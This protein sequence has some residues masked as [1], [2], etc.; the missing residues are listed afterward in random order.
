MQLEKRWLIPGARWEQQKRLLDRFNISPLV[1]Q[2]L[3]NRGLTEFEDV[4]EFLY[5]DTGKMVDWNKIP[6]IDRAVSRIIEA[7]RK[8]EKVLVYGDYDVDGITA[9]A[10]LVSVLERMGMDDVDYYIPDRMEEG[11]GL[12]E[13]AITWAGE[14]GVDLVITVD[15]GIN[16]NAEVEL[17][18]RLGMD[19][20]ITDHHEPPRDLPQATAVVNPKLGEEKRVRDLAGVGVAFKL[21]QA[22]EARYREENNRGLG[23]WESIDLVTLGTVA[24]MVPLL[25][26]NRILV[27]K[28]LEYLPCS[29]R[30]GIQELVRVSG[31]AGKEINCG[32]VGF[33]LAPRINAVGRLG[34]ASLA[35]EL[36]LT[37]SIQRAAELAKM[38]DSENRERQTVEKQIFQDV[39]AQIERQVDLD[40][41]RVIVLSSPLWHS[42]VIGIVASKIV[43]R[44]YR[45][46]I[47]IAQ[48]GDYGKASARSIS[49]FDIY[50]ALEHC[51]DLL[52]R[53]GGHKQAA[54][55]TIKIDKIE[56][57]RRAINELADRWLTEEQMQPTIKLDC[58]MFLHQVDTTLVEQLELLEPFGFGNPGPVFC[59]RE[60]NLIDCRQVGRDKKHA[61]MV[62]ASGNTSLPAIGFNIQADQFARGNHKI[63]LAFVPEKNYWQGKVSLQLN[64]KDIRVAKPV[65]VERCDLELN[66]GLVE[67]RER[68]LE[69]LE[70][71]ERG[72]LAVDH[73][74]HQDWLTLEMAAVLAEGHPVVIVTPLTSISR[75]LAGVARLCLPEIKVQVFDG[76]WKS[77]EQFFRDFTAQ[78]VCIM[79][80]P[81]FR[82]FHC[83]LP[84]RACLILVNID[85]DKEMLVNVVDQYKWYLIG[86]RRAAPDTVYQS[87]VRHS[88]EE[89]V[90]APGAG[91]GVKKL[92]SVFHGGKPGV[93]FTSLPSEVE[94]LA[95]HLQQYIPGTVMPY[96]ER[97]SVDQKLNIINSFQKGL[98]QVIVS[99]HG[100]PLI[101]DFPLEI[102][103]LDAPFN[104]WDYQR[105]L[106]L[107]GRVYRLF[108]GSSWDK[109]ERLLQQ[110]FLKRETLQL[111]YSIIKKLQ[112]NGGAVT[113]DKIIR[114]LRAGQI[115]NPRLIET[116]ILVLK[117][118]GLLAEENGQFRIVPVKDKKELETN[119]RYVEGNAEFQAF[120]DIKRLLGT[121]KMG[122]ANNNK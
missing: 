87:P 19:M 38:L 39:L 62:V 33:T 6:G 73:A 107:K 101:F 89:L 27:K 98:I 34:N 52:E 9:T 50:Q 12:N 45:P 91:N 16:A 83:Q 44:F 7:L 54:G 77:P 4:E 40:K 3:I 108:T 13:G 35:V 59:C 112:E 60:V 69:I 95:H 11:Y 46:T 68:V 80:Q 53:F 116:G 90:A 96:N 67:E 32:H 106:P 105:M 120:V 22:L 58:E 66:P 76:S 75:Q 25:W 97:L 113:G 15:C 63:D 55:F 5:P 64:V 103:L 100:F 117:E 43:D 49:G 36:L 61:K 2:V 26:E 119:W 85:I 88:V 56:Q 41:E 122:L 114:G 31:L 20:I 94:T 8:Q 24:D 104:Y 93:V 111:L 99:T 21:A 10:L 48:E 37:K 74:S 1:A 23:V 17:A 18:N 51:G 30:P 70:R 86:E 110:L 118:L 92:A 121:E 109:Q 42:G 84:E 57:F 28:G 72:C 65:V 47:L 14:Q 71:H 29:T 82:E 102:M 79:S 81:A 78:Q 115:T